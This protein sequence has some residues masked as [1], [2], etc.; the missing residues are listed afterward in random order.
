MR[1]LLTGATGFLGRHVVAAATD[2]TVTRVTRALTASSPDEVALGPSAWTRRHF[3][4]ALD[5]ARP[6]VVLHCA[7]AA[8][9]RDVRACMD[10]N[11]ILAAEL[12]G[13]AAALREPP[14]VILVGSAAEYGIVPADAQPVAETHP[15]APRT[16]YAVAK[17]AQSLLGFA[18]AMR[19]QQVLVARLFNPVGVGMPSGLAL[20]SFARRIVAAGPGAVMLVGD[21]SAE[22]DFLDV[23]EAARLLLALAAMSHWPWRVVNI[24]SGRTYRLGDLLEGLITASG[25]RV[26]IESDSSLMRPGDMPR[27]TGSTERLRS[28]GLAPQH[29]NFA[30]L[31]PRLLAEA[32]ALGRLSQLD[33]DSGDFAPSEW[34]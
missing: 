19:G 3:A 12:L 4:A 27:L 7:G 32:R 1:L 21:L 9:S 20:P 22:R 23:E 5:T 11:A 29:P 25:V 34:R 24:C 18:A 30:T 15:C 14:R 13:A 28:V 26:R 31:L 2:W 16:D 8:S 10:T 17:C 33:L 6:D